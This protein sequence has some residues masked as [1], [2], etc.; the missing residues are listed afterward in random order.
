MSEF[1]EIKC[2]VNLERDIKSSYNLDMIFSFLKEK[3]KLNIIIYNK[4]LQN[5]FGVNIQNY[6]DISVTAISDI[7]VPEARKWFL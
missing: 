1:E 4:Q 2:T 7:A 6:K 3:E 5:K